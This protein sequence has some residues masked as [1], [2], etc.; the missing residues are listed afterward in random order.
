MLPLN[1][2]KFNA[3]FICKKNYLNRKIADPLLLKVND[4]TQNKKSYAKNKRSVKF[5]PDSFY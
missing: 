5:V 4:N 3:F 1:N 2:I